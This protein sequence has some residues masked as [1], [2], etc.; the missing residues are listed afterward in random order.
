MAHPAQQKFCEHVKNKFPKSFNGIKVLD[1]GSLD[2]NGSNKP[3]FDNCEY[4]GLD[5]APGKNV[6]IVCIAHEYLAPE[7]A[8]DTIIST[9]CFEHDMYLSKTLLSIVRMLKPGGLF[10][11][12]CAT[13][14]RNA[15]G[16]I[17]D[18]PEDSPLTAKIPGWDVFY[19]NVTEKDIRD[20]LDID[21][22]FS[23]YPFE[24]VGT[25]SWDMGLH[26]Y[27]IKKL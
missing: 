10:I 15:H 4:I 23:N 9:E 21:K 20:I 17:N 2:I 1:V 27:G 8:F 25:L 13:E 19:K 14:G 18:T 16:T 6:D 24:I 3:L 26:F 7:E 22:I 11:F 12:T 5:I